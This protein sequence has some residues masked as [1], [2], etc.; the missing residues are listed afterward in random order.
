MHINFTLQAIAR[1]RRVCVRGFVTLVTTMV[2]WA[3]SPDFLLRRNRN[4]RIESIPKGIGI[5]SGTWKNRFAQPY[6]W[7][8]EESRVIRQV[9][10]SRCGETS[11]KPGALSWD[12]NKAVG[13]SAHG[14][15]PLSY[16]MKGTCSHSRPRLAIAKNSE[17]VIIQPP[18]LCDMELFGMTELLRY[19]FRKFCLDQQTEK[20]FYFD[21]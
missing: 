19:I 2:L 15:Q 21:L 8:T 6:N 5:E 14:F 12:R 20:W 7:R 11:S 18:R 9:E 13:A 16:Q 3:R 10:P 4:E 1:T 17:N